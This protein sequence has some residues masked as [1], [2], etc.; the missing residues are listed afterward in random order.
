MIT[1]M[2]IVMITIIA[3]MGT[4]TIITMI[5]RTATRQPAIGIKAGEGKPATP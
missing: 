4:T 1:S 5:M 2:V 3:I